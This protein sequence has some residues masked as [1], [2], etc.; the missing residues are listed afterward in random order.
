M[1]VH[2]PGSGLSPRT[3]K[4]GRSIIKTNQGSSG[5]PLPP[6][7]QSAQAQS[8]KLPPPQIQRAGSL[9]RAVAWAGPFQKTMW[10]VPYP[11]KGLRLAHGVSGVTLLLQSVGLEGRALNE[12]PLSHLKI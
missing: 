5:L 12:R 9:Q 11:A 7:A 1:A 4:K 10:A 8:T 3:G 2:K 6:Q